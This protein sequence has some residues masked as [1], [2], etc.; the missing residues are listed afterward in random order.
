MIVVNLLISLEIDISL[1]CQ[2]P[3]SMHLGLPGKGITP[4]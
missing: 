1:L 4:L 2:P 3:M